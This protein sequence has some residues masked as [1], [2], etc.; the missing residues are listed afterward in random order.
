M[1]CV[2]S[3]LPVADALLSDGAGAGVEPP[4]L[5]QAAVPKSKIDEMRMAKA[6]R[7]TMLQFYP[8]SP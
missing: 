3:S 7:K 8:I 4:E 5:E 1:N 2:A 6:R